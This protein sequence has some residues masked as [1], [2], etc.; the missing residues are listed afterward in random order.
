MVPGSGSVNFSCDI[1]VTFF[2]DKTG[3]EGRR[4]CAR[5]EIAIL[6]GFHSENAWAEGAGGA[7]KI[8]LD[9]ALRAAC[10]GFHSGIF[11][12]P[13]RACT[14]CI[15]PGRGMKAPGAG[16]VRAKPFSLWE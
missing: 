1:W 4:P 15:A 14:A 5:G 6:R 10:P 16:A 13:F 12:A 3:E 8:I 9:G 7:A 11:S 2:V